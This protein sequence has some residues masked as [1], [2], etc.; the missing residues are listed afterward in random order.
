MFDIGSLSLFFPEDPS[1][2][3]FVRDFCPF[4]LWN[5]PNGARSSAQVEAYRSVYDVL[6]NRQHR[7]CVLSFISFYGGSTINSYAFGSGFSFLAAP[8]SYVGQQN[9]LPFRVLKHGITQNLVL[10]FIFG[11]YFFSFLSRD[12][13]SNYE[14]L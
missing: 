9:I 4:R 1:P 6:R 11:S 5:A 12:C 13:D 7:D 3:G 14:I 10:Y 2:S 8:L